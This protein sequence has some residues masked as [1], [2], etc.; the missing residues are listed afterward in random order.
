MQRLLPAA[1][2]INGRGFIQRGI[3]ASQGSQIH[4]RVVSKV[5]PYVADHHGLAEGTVT[6]Q[7]VNRFFNEA[8]SQQ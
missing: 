6:A 8:Q 7:E 2:A 1:R 5:F 4:D 3:D